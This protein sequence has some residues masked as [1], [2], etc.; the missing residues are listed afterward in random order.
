MYVIFI[1]SFQGEHNVC[2]K[3]IISALNSYTIEKKKKKRYLDNNCIL[4]ENTIWTL[5][6]KKPV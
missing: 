2:V 6:L 4:L 1:L 5:L 3:H